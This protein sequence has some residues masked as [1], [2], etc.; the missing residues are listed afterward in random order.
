MNP[1]GPER[2]ES[3][4]SGVSVPVLGV[5]CACRSL[6]TPVIGFFPTR[7]GAQLT[8]PTDA[9]PHYTTS[10]G[11]APEPTFRDYCRRGI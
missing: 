1:F 10:C 2:R 8:D 11:H 7:I 6:T 9:A 4:W 5:P 3:D